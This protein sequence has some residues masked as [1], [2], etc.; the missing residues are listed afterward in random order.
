MKA[1][2]DKN[3]CSSPVAARPPS[4]KRTRGDARFESGDAST[5]AGDGRAVVFLVDGNLA[6]AVEIPADE[7]DLP[8][9][10]LGYDAELE[11]KTGE[12]NGCVEVAEMVGSV[13]SGG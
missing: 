3:A 10:E 13:D 2:P 5:E 6:G 11:G 4:G 7:G 1:Q 9:R 12:E 8:E